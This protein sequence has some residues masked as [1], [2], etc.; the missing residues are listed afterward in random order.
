MSNVRMDAIYCDFTHM[1]VANQYSDCDMLV[2][3]ESLMSVYHLPAAQKDRSCL[4]RT[5]LRVSRQAR[6]AHRLVERTHVGEH[7]CHCS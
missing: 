7:S 1:A 5:L 4:E 6:T 2:S 3:F